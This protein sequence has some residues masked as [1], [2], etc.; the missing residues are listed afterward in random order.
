MSLFVSHGAPTFALEPGLA[1]PALTELGKR[2]PRPSAVLVVSPHWMTEGVRVGT[3]AQP[4]TL[5]D[6]GGFPP[7]LYQLSY[8]A[9]GHPDLAGVALALLE[10]AGWKAQA[11][12]KRGLDHGAWVPL[13]HLFPD[14]SVPVFQ[15]SM[16]RDLDSAAAWQM[17]QA[18]LPLEQENVLIIGSGSLTHNLYEVRWGDR[19]ASNYAQAFTQWIRSRVQA[20]DHKQLINALENAPHAR[21]AHPTSEHYLPLLVAAGAAGE[22]CSG[23]LIDGGIEHGVLAMDAFVFSKKAS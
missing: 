18:L 14:P 7:E 10:A 5:H 16:P 11:D 23:T 22:H 8:P 15:I 9:P 3:S 13:M 6:F 19:N 17:G 2:L 20:G 12:A 4:E 1:G 21:R